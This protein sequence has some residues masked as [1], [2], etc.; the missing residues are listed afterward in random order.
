MIRALTPVLLAAL[1]ATSLAAQEP[2]T[3]AVARAPLAA[4][5]DDSMGGRLVGTAGARAAAEYLAGRLSALGLAP[6]G[7]SGGYLQ[8]IPLERRGIADSS[9]VLLDAGSRAVT[10]AWGQTFAVEWGRPD[11]SKTY[12]AI[13]GDLYTRAGIDSTFKS[14]AGKFLVIN[15]PDGTGLLVQGFPPTGRP[16]GIIALFSTAR[17][18][19]RAARTARPAPVTFIG[20]NPGNP[21]LV[22]IADRDSVA[23]ALGSVAQGPAGTPAPFR[24]TPRLV[25]SI[26]PVDGWNVVATRPGGDPGRRGEYVLYTAQFDHVGRADDPAGFCRAVGADQVCNGAGAVSGAVAELLGARRAA[27][28]PAPHRSMLFAWLGAEEAGSLGLR[29]LLAHPPAPTDSIIAVIGLGPVG[30][31]AADSL[32]EGGVR[33]LAPDLLRVVDSVAQS[34]SP[35]FA[36]IGRFER[37]DDP[38]RIYCRTPAAGL[39]TMGIPS[40][41]FSSGYYPEFRRAD[42]SVALVDADKVARVG[43]LAYEVGMALGD[44]RPRLATDSTLSRTLCR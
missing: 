3:P 33:E 36:L 8:H 26:I 17:F 14:A 44:A 43:R 20:A 37:L 18:R 27:T 16:A 22:I 28:D 19:V 35:P 13:W 34:D 21:P 38:R 7:D 10:L 1:V 15:V 40:I 30:R 9:T 11:S 41:T 31:G 32:E 5:A 29:W 4:L 2:F 39:A 6:A 42:D 23:A 24:I 12:D 25:A